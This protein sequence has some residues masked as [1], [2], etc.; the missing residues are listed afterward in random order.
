MKGSRAGRFLA[1]AGLIVVADLAGAA[2]GSLLG[3]AYVLGLMP[4]A[5]FE[6]ILPPLLA[7]AVG[8]V[9][10]TFAVLSVLFQMPR[11]DRDR[12]TG[13]AG[14]VVPLLVLGLFGFL[15]TRGDGS[16]SAFAM[17]ALTGLPAAALITTLVGS[18]W[19]FGRR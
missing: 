17:L 16:E 3:M 9:L 4:N 14:M 13:A 19:L 8:C 12:V 10:G 11:I 7:G 2:V 15:T 1:K 5:G 6:G 18:S